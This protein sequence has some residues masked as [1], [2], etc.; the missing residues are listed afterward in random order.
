MWEEGKEALEDESLEYYCD[1][2]DA[3][4]GDRSKHCGDCNRCV[5]LFDHHCKWMNNCVG[6]KNYWDFLFL[7]GCVLLQSII[8]L[9]HLGFTLV[10]SLPFL[11]IDSGD[12]S[13][14]E[15]FKIVGYFIFVFAFVLPV[16]INI[17][18]IVFTVL[19]IRL[20]IKLL[21]TDFTAY[22][23]LVFQ[24]DRDEW[25]EELDAE[26]ITKEEYDSRVK[27][28]LN[29]ENRKKRSKIIHQIKQDE[30]EQKL[31]DKIQKAGG[32]ELVKSDDMKK[33]AKYYYYCGNQLCTPCISKKRNSS[34]YKVPEK[35]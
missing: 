14:E 27:E 22:E 16:I 17:G 34:T 15:T 30:K 23:Y 10:F 7:I 8:F 1:V 18:I 26:T 5:E 21:K 24:S 6:A 13:G 28:A 11:T 25:K 20:H 32:K 4:V 33:E 12:S 2:C 19:L 9:I 31:K 29:R 35:R 3:Y